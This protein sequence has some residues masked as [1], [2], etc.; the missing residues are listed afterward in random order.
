MVGSCDYCGEYCAALGLTP[1]EEFALPSGWVPT[2]AAERHR[3][4]VQR[5]MECLGDGVARLRP[6]DH[7]G[8]LHDSRGRRLERCRHCYSPAHDWG[9]WDAT[10]PDDHSRCPTCWSKVA[11][12]LALL[13]RRGAI[14]GAPSASTWSVAELAADSLEA[15]RST[16]PAKR[17]HVEAA[18]REYLGRPML[19]IRWV[20]SP[21]GVANAF[22]DAMGPQGSG[23]Q[24]L[25]PGP[26]GSDPW[27]NRPWE[28][29]P[30]S[31]RTF[32][33]PAV[34]NQFGAVS[35]RLFEVSATLISRA[36]ASAAAEAFGVGSRWAPARS[37]VRRRGSVRL[38]HPAGHRLDRCARCILGRRSG[39]PAPA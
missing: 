14:K 21:L 37:I 1:A 38:P 27:R 6:M 10:L 32:A 12:G 4:W 17:D 24:D 31:I 39:L 11:G 7:R 16:A 8:P 34:R 19:P 20:G 18:I 26:W 22:L 33:P 5:R 35:D 9:D 2:S 30:W 29:Q 15:L 25:D 36:V 23:T 28:P 13:R 3:E